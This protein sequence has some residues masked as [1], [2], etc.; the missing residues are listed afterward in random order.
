MNYTVIILCSLLAS[1]TLSA[2]ENVVWVAGAI[3]VLGSI[4]LR[5][6]QS[7][8]MQR[9]SHSIAD[10]IHQNMIPL[11]SKWQ[12]L[13]AKDLVSLAGID[14]L[15]HVKN[16]DLRDNN[17]D[18][19]SSND[20]NKQLSLEN[21]N[22]AHNNISQIHTDIF[23]WLP[24]LKHLDLR[25]NPICFDEVKKEQIRQAVP[26]DCTVVF[27]DTVVSLVHSNSFEDDHTLYFEYNK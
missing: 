9:H 12:L 17:I 18:A 24:Q 21:L 11:G 3:P 2:M 16:L 27:E 10:L 15:S 1:Q 25:G 14:K 20:I 22:L 13:Q 26:D 23:V 6:K 5:K 7:E 19:I 4:L 8:Q